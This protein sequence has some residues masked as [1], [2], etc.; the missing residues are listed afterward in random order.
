MSVSTAYE[1]L[2]TG[3]S[4]LDDVVLTEAIAEFPEAMTAF[5]AFLTAVNLGNAARIVECSKALAAHVERYV[6]QVAQVTA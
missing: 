5:K 3:Y 6:E 4:E 2:L 1:D